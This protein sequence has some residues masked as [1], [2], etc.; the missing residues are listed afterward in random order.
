M[1]IKSISISQTGK[2][3]DH[4]EDSLYIDDKLGLWLI[5]DGMGGHACGEVASDLAIKTI[6][7]ETK[8]KP[9]NLAIKKAHHHI[10]EQ[11]QKKTK[12][13]GMGTTIVAAQAIKTGFKIAWVGDSR[14]YLFAAELEQITIDHTFVQD[15]VR[16]EVLTQEEAANHPQRN[17]IVRSL[18]MEQG[19]FYVEEITIK[20][21]MSGYLLLCS[22]GVTDYLA[23]DQLH[24]LFK[25]SLSLK[26]MATQL[27]AAVLETD[28]GDNFSFVII[29]FKL[30]WPTK[31]FNKLRFK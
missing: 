23:D 31:W 15:L 30:K 8:Q 14:A 20:P 26:D 10:L 21:K 17:L 22:D 5:A 29:D 16:R 25:Q 18:G 28:A 11:G 7:E 2:V 13:K 27:A 12:Q 3:R 24:A 6:T 1:I 19:T 4:N 9:L